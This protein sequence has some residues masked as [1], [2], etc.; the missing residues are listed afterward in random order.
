MPKSQRDAM[1]RASSMQAGCLDPH[2]PRVRTFACG[3]ASELFRD[4]TSLICWSARSRLPC[5]S[6]NATACA[7]RGARPHRPFW[8]TTDAAS[9]HG[10]QPSA[11]RR[12]ALCQRTVATS[13]SLPKGQHAAT[14]TLRHGPRHRVAGQ[15][16]A[17]WISKQHA[18]EWP[19]AC[20]N[21]APLPCHEAC[22]VHLESVAIAA[23]AG[24]QRRDCIPDVHSVHRAAYDQDPNEA[25]RFYTRTRKRP[26][27]DVPE[28]ADLPPDL[29]ANPKP[30]LCFMTDRLICDS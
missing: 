20:A 26:S 3:I 10:R 2:D 24:N 8:S 7:A 17:H 5:E 29:C 11:A 9:I 4:A 27:Q 6:G 28:M 12:L 22:V 25:D 1:D 13:S 19:I 16:A 23:A 14:V 30:P 15:K 18:Q 21:P